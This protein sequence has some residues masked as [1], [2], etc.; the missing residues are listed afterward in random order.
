MS[1]DCKTLLIVCQVYPPDPA[2]VGQHVAD[3]AEHMSRNGWRVSAYTASRGYEDPSKVYAS[4]ELRNGVDVHRLPLSSFGKTSLIWRVLGGSLF[5]LQATVRGI[6]YRRLDCVLVS[7][8]PPFAG[9]GGVVLSIIR[10]V[11]LVW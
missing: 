8:S 11:P 6:F 1:R 10:H 3:L 5:L 9:L 2:A 4:R 7:T